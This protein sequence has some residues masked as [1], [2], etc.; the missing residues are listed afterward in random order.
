MRLQAG[1]ALAPCRSLRAVECPGAHAMQPLEPARLRVAL[2]HGRGETPPGGGWT[3]E[4]LTIDELQARITRGDHW[5]SAHLR[6]GY[7]DTEHYDSSNTITLDLDGTIELAE[8]QAIPL[9]QRHCIATTTTRSHGDPTKQEGKPSSDRFR[10]L[11]R[12]DL[13][14]TADSDGY[15]MHARIARILA[16]HLGLLQPRQGQEPERLLV[17]GASFIAVMPWRGNANAQLW[18]GGGEPL[19]WDWLDMAAEELVEERK[20]RLK[21]QVPAGSEIPDAAIAW[22]L[23]NVLRKSEDGE[24]ATYYAKVLNAAGATQSPEVWQAFVDWRSGGHHDSRKHPLKQA[25]RDFWKPKRISRGSLIAMAD[26]QDPTW[27]ERIPESLQWWKGQSTGSSIL[28]ARPEVIAIQEPG[29]LSSFAEEESTA[30][31][32]TQLLAGARPSDA[33]REHQRRRNNQ[34]QQEPATTELEIHEL[35]RQ[36]YWLQVE[37]RYQGEVLS[38]E[39][40]AEK[41]LHVQGLLMEK[42][43]VILRNPKR[44]EEELLRIFEQEHGIQSPSR[45]NMRPRSVW[46]YPDVEQ[47]PVLEGLMMQGETYMMHGKAGAGKSTL[48]LALARSVI[49][50]PGHSSFLGY[51]SPPGTYGNSRVMILAT[52]SG[53]ASIPTIKRY[54]KWLQIT[55]ATHWSREYLKVIGPSHELGATEWRFRLYDLH[56]LAE[57]LDEAAAAGKPYRLLIVDS[58]KAVMPAGFRVGDQ[59][60]TE[61]MRIVRAIC[62]SRSCACLFIHHTS[63][64]DETP[65]GIAALE[66]MTSG[67]FYL[68]RDEKTNQ[69]FFKITKTRAEM[70]GNNEIPYRISGG[71]LIAEEPDGTAS[72]EERGR[73]NDDGR[74][75][76]LRFLDRHE[77]DWCADA[78]LRGESHLLYT[79]P[80]QK[81]LPQLLRDSGIDHPAWSSARSIIR[82]IDSLIEE[83]VLR[84]KGHGRNTGLVIRREVADPDPAL[85]FHSD[86]FL[87]AE[88]IDD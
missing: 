8:F 13:P 85:D 29:A 47:P 10:A 59:A 33:N 30:A 44:I 3:N 66:E 42:S 26:E 78:R 9:V 55:D 18:L 32:V 62:H 27:R 61:Y 52:D 12:L 36:L 64:G 87:D 54:L 75:V 35:L 28:M 53:E 67:N 2:H 16:G 51:S 80:A 56:R 25:E 65:Q 17:D 69:H 74:D 34:S 48:L 50:V 21:P 71:A 49:G 60:V 31:E 1:A 43:P 11:F 14:L 77:R 39:A 79:G 68:R 82:L 70:R 15:E 46:E 38:E 23:R 86:P 45:L 63:K 41:A 57:W 73:G 40:A 58:L 88:G 4:Q 76:L 22:A 5:I 84:R 24:R 7:R 81:S 19:P 83:G 37:S 72:D 6:A 20:A